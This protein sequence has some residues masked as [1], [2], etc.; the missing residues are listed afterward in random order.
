MGKQAMNKIQHIDL[1]KIY[2]YKKNGKY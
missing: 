2:F 1:D